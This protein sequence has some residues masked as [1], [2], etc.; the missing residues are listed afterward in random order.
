MSEEEYQIHRQKIKERVGMGPPT[1]STIRGGDGIVDENDEMNR[2]VDVQDSSVPMDIRLLEIL[3][4]DDPTALIETLSKA[5]KTDDVDAIRETLTGH[6]IPGR[7]PI[8]YLAV[9]LGAKNIVK[10]LLQKYNVPV[11]SVNSEGLTLLHMALYI[12]NEE[13]AEMLTDAGADPTAFDE[14]GESSLELYESFPSYEKEQFKNV[15]DKWKKIIQDKKQQ[16]QDQLDQQMTQV[17]T[18]QQTPSHNDENTSTFEFLESADAE[19]VAEIPQTP[20]SITISL[21]DVVFEKPSA[22][23]AHDQDNE[24]ESEDEDVTTEATKTEQHQQN[25]GDL[26]INVDSDKVASDFS[27]IS[28]TPGFETVEAPHSA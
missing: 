15:Y 10:T 26:E 3:R 25:V 4:L 5:L 22:E 9:D 24:K 13:I 14:D 2:V 7:D 20:E 27:N 21:D 23:L 8:L 1:L 11:H 28:S 6:I 19:T 12:G 18:T 17:N 16:Q